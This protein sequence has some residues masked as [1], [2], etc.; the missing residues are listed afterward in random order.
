[1]RSALQ[2]HFG[3]L[4]VARQVGAISLCRVAPAIGL[5]VTSIGCGIGLLASSAWLI[6]RA[7]QRPPVFALS[8]A[9]G[10]VQAFALGRG[11]SRYF[12]RLSI[13]GLALRVLSRLRLYLFDTL[14]PLV[15]GGAHG[16]S[17]GAAVSGLV[18]DA[19]R[20]TEGFARTMSTSVDVGAS[21]G[22]G[23]L[24]AVLVEPGVGAVLLVGSLATVALVLW[25]SGLGRASARSE[26]TERSELADLVA[27][28]MG[29][30][31]EL[32]AYG[33]EDLLVTQ[34]D[35]ID[36][37]STVTALRRTFTNG[38][39]RMAMTWAAGGTLVATL[40]AGL[41]AHSAHRLSGVMLAVVVFVT[42]AVL[43][44]CAVLPGARFDAH[45]AAAA[46]RRIE[47]LADLDPSVH[48]PDT[49]S[50]EPILPP[51]A[52]LEDADVSI[53]DRALLSA[54]SL[55][56]LPGARL[57]LTGS[58]GSGK[59]SALFALMHFL[60]CSRGRA[61]LGETDVADLTRAT[62][63]GHVAWMDE[64]VYVFA[65]SLA[66]NLRL[67]RTAATDAECVEVLDRVG[68][69]EWSRSLPDGLETKLGAGGQPMS[70]GERQRLGMARIIM[71]SNEIA[72][73][74]E[75][76]A[77]V[78]PTGADRLLAELL[79]AAGNCAV[80]VVSHEPVLKDH[81]DEIVA[82]EAGRV[83]DRIIEAN[84]SMRDSCQPHHAQ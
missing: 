4:S 43:D 56:L 57:A 32:V 81:V 16:V 59:T 11:V 69:S 1:M 36:R 19:D 24:M 39:A 79:D 15:P 61:T 74:D 3:S 82:L 26:V 65:A 20:V 5:G 34:L 25:V 30:A 71:G 31:R 2:R 47:D 51:S 62:I 84:Q 54:V 64:D 38:M 6:T 18:S 10:A 55:K 28:T 27:E 23:T 73:L 72:L 63:A 67:A 78:D 9:I 52:A 35:A 40:V 29:S 60:E 33:R 68:L 77:H 53:G 70:A 41:T 58:S 49:N 45:T 50:G 42:I 48:E 46:A 12:E 14:E 44:G 22:I 7:S 75:P 37:R 13:H 76:T 66:E 8:V 80:L 17:R 83:V 21:I